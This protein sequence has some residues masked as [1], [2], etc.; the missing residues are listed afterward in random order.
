[1]G[2]VGKEVRRLREERGWG[3]AKLAVEAGTAVSAISQIETGRRNP[4]SAT[5]IKLARA[6]EVEV[7]DLF[8][9]AQPP[10]DFDATD[11]E[12]VEEIDAL[13]RQLRPAA[14]EA[15]ELD[16]ATGWVDSGAQSALILAKLRELGKRRQELSPPL[17][18][19]TERAGSLP[20]IIYHREPTDEERARLRAEYPDAVE[21]EDRGA[22]LVW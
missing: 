17:A 1:M 10:L 18:T 21:L 20:E 11:L 9:L 13:A 12:T 7:R 19:I 4:N 8:P 14:K 3:Q 15:V 16:H 5:L 22:V 2:E 6:L